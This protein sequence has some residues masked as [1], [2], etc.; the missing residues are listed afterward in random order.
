LAALWDES[1]DA[2]TETLY[3]LAFAEH[4]AL[5]V[6]RMFG[7]LA[8]GGEF[9]S[10][11]V[12]IGLFRDGQFAGAELFELEDLDRARAR[13]EELRPGPLRIPPNSASRAS[14]RVAETFL[15]RDPAA[16][17]ALAS[18]DFRFEDRRR[19]ALLSGDVALWV[20]NLEL[21]RSWPGLR[22][23]RES[24]GTAGDRIAL[25]RLVFAGDPEGSDF[26][27]EFLRLT[28]VDSD[29][30]I[31]AAI[32]FDPKDRAGAFAEAQA[33]FA[34]GEAAGSEAQ[35]AIT[36]FG[37]SFRRRDWAACHGCY[38]GDAVMQDHRRLGFGSVSIDGWVESWRVL[39]EL[40]P[41]VSAEQFRLLVWSE[42]GRVSVMRQHGTR[43]GGPFESVFVGVFLTRGDHIERYELFDL[44][45]T[46][47]ALARFA[48][49][50]AG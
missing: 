43:E 44:E 27:G 18:A 5:N 22:T 36:A 7:T 21:V 17:R 2:S 26:E 9:E 50:S 4:G 42:R 8:D 29:G 20:Q 32:H 47:R 13:F 12:R 35:A 3:Y 31:R 39:V 45:D 10:L 34:A 25:D 49:L 28:E 23:T 15:A 6:A 30:R 33:R 41:D 38:T 46:E 14:D 40:A 37:D 19:R 11:F 24:I 48:E 16:L 1:P